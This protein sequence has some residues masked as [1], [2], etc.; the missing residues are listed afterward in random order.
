MVLD[1]PLGGSPRKHQRDNGR[2]DWVLRRGSGYEAA[3][4]TALVRAGV[5]H[6]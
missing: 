2:I 1:R 4:D 5:N 6:G 3:I